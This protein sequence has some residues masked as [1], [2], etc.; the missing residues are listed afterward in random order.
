M[1]EEHKILFWNDVNDSAFKG[2]KD[3]WERGHKAVIEPDYVWFLH[4][5]TGFYCLILRD[6]EAGNLNGYI[7]IPKGHP[8][9]L[10]RP[11]EIKANG[12]VP[13]VHGGITY[14]ALNLGVKEKYLHEALKKGHPFVG[15]MIMSH[16]KEGTLEFSKDLWVLGFDTCHMG[17]ERPGL[18]GKRLMTTR[19]VKTYRD[20]KYVGGELDHLARQA[21]AA[22]TGKIE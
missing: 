21:L 15:P 22:I 18:Y 11:E 7:G 13:I 8:W 17:D 20:I 4:E 12:Q 2:L 5:K 19:E 9:Y 6:W 14:A 3:S 16:D 1:S 10:K